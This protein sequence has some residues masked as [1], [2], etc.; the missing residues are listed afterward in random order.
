[1]SEARTVY[2]VVCCDRHTD[3][4]ITVHATR[5]GADE[6]IAEFQ[7]EYDAEI[8]KWTEQNYGRDQGWVR[9]VDT[10]D[11]GPSARIEETELLP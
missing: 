5:Q 4:A 8:Y 11:D 10:F 3:N 6:M 1:M 9:Y 2:V 7:A